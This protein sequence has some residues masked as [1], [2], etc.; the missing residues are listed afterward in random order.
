MAVVAVLGD[1]SWGTAIALHLAQDPNHQVRLWSARWENARLLRE[2]RE[3]K[4][5]LPGIR[6]PQNIL[7]TDNELEA[8]ESTDVWVTA[9]PTTYLRSTIS[10]FQNKRQSPPI[11]VSLTKGI[12]IETFRRPSEIIEEVLQT[13]RIGVLSGPSHAEEVCKGKPCSLVMASEDA[14]LARQ[15]QEMFNTE[16]F[17]V[18]TNPD[19]IGVELSGALKNVIGIAAGI[20]DGLRFGDNAKSALLTRGLVEMARFGMAFG[21][22]HSTF[23]GLAGIGDLI[24][25]CFSPYGRNRRVGERLGQGDSLDKIISDSPMI[26]E[27]IT[28]SRSVYERTHSMGLEMPIMTGV[29][30]V[31]YRGKSPLEAVQE[32]MSRRLKKE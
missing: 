7:L 10:R 31:L 12:E 11:V 16:R 17:R 14:T 19:M 18:Y 8:I 4:R 6:I 3:N 1:G 28:T 22:E 20:C 13:D 32:L 23:Y 9:I 27:G 25:T 24:T 5:F 15:L 29:Y 30:E 21:A 2:E 26:A